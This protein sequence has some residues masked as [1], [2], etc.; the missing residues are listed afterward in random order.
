MPPS[1]IG[2]WKAA[3]ENGIGARKREKPGTQQGGREINE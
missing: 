3:I 2:S 1:I